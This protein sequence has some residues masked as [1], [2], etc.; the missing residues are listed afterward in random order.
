MHEW[1]GYLIYSLPFKWTLVHTA[2]VS[3][4]LA[5][6]LSRIPA[7]YRCAFADKHLRYPDLKRANIQLPEEW[8]KTPNL[9][10]TTMDILQAM[11][12]QIV[13][14]EK[15]SKAVKTK[16]LRALSKELV[17]LHDKLEGDVDVD[18]DQFTKKVQEEIA[19]MEAAAKQ[20]WIDKKEMSQQEATPQKAE[21]A[22]LAAVSPRVLLT[23]QF[24]EK[25]QNEDTEFNKIII[26]LRT[27][28]KEGIQSKILKKYRLLND[29][30]LVTRKNKNLP[31][32]EPGN[33]R[34]MCNNKM[35]II[36][37]S[38]LHIMG[39]HNGLNTLVKLFSLAYKTK[40]NTLAFAKIVA[41]G[42]NA[43]RMHRP[44]NKRAIPPGRIPI[45]KEA[46]ECWHIDHMVFK[47][48]TRYRRRKIAAAL[49][50]VDLYSG[51]LISHLVPDMT[52]KTTIKCF[53]QIFSTMPPPNK[54]VMDNATS[55][56]A[57]VELAAF[58]KT[59][60]VDL[61]TTITPYNS[62][63]NKCERAN[64]I[65]RHTMKLV[66]EKFKRN[67]HFDLYHTVIEMINNRPLSLTTHPHIRE[68]MGN[69]QMLQES[70]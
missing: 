24:I 55:L 22:A 31:F 50:I 30:I 17:T 63:G 26:Q 41:M 2:G 49:N 68:A 35:A 21:I 61:V 37:L 54:I 13:F 10:L 59:K 57:S 11:H 47:K 3:L 38:Y 44:V 46:N 23:P 8:K 16:R 33:M 53:K 48:D 20:E 9:V 52:V 1:L 69:T 18:V 45:P 66:K 40:G 56:G 67:S 36:I 27:M 70:V 42:C 58:L 6:A 14:V 29:S 32:H 65:L 62:K 43:C 19:T 5:D 60:G 12:E 4:P 34:I 25:H 64:L 7:P 51:L 39:G 28:E 15:S